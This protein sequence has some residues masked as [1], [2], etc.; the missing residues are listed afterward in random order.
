MLANS[1]TSIEARFARRNTVYNVYRHCCVMEHLCTIMS[2]QKAA[3]SR[4]NTF[5]CAE[6]THL[7]SNTTWSVRDSQCKQFSV[8][9]FACL[10][11]KS[12]L[13]SAC[14]KKQM[15]HSHISSATA[16]VRLQGSVKKL[17]S[18]VEP[19]QSFRIIPFFRSR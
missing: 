16:K 10:H 8:L 9:R 4:A 17:V 3:T 5:E 6:Q 18:Y 2:Q 1:Q 14:S 19:L 15:W 12:L 11:A 7:F 13:T